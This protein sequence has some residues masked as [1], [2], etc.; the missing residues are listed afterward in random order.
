VLQVKA[1]IVVPPARTELER[2]LIDE[3]KSSQER[4]N[5]DAQRG[6][7][8][9]NGG[10]YSSCTLPAPS[11]RAQNGF[12]ERA[13]DVGRYSTLPGRGFELLP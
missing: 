6:G 3:L 12:Y 13:D 4:L 11:L 1:R 8:S 10:L 2:R 9:V 7:R 5:V